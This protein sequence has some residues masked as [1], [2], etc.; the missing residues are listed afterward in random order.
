MRFCTAAAILEHYSDQEMYFNQ[1]C[2]DHFLVMACN[3]KMPKWFATC[4]HPRE[5]VCLIR[6]K[7]PAKLWPY[8]RASHSI[9]SPNFP[10]AY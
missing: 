10:F 9:N 3:C 2:K 4:Y 7:F 6:E 8:C 5:T 1:E